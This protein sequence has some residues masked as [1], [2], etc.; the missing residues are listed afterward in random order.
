[1][2]LPV[3]VSLFGPSKEEEWEVAL[4]DKML[5]DHQVRPSLSEVKTAVISV[6]AAILLQG[7]PMPL[8]LTLVFSDD[9][10]QGSIF[11]ARRRYRG[12]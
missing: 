3:P 7:T 12:A 2:C 5:E 10:P 8:C 4:V 9:H 6:A 11:P 1:M